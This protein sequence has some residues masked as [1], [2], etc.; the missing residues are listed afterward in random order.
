LLVL[1]AACRPSAPTTDVCDAPGAGTV[2]LVELGSDAPDGS[3]PPFQPWHD[4]DTANV[5]IGGQGFTMIV[6][7]VRASGSS[8][9][10]CMPA[11]LEIVDASG[12]ITQSHDPLHGYGDGSQRLSHAIY[13]PANYPMSGQTIHVSATLL[14]VTAQVALV[15]AH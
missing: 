10:D 4:G 7:R 1:L 13:L 11:D 6:A 5:V 2:A 15:V 14:G 8:V 9:P 3:E 12:P